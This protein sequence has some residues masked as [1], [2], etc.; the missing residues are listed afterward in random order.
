MA[1]KSKQGNLFEKPEWYFSKR[2]MEEL[3]ERLMNSMMVPHT[4]L[5]TKAM[6]KQM[7]VGALSGFNATVKDVA[8]K[9]D[10]IIADIEVNMRNELQ[11]IGVF[12]EE[13]EK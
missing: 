9:G 11:H 3:Q 8:V 6:A 12:F 4:F 7:V 10:E 5:M 1:K 13:K 2:D